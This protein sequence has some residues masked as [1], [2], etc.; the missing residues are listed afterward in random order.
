VSVL[1]QFLAL[2]CNHSTMDNRLL[3]LALSTVWLCVLPVLTLATFEA[4]ARNF[5]IAENAIQIH[6]SASLAGREQV[7]V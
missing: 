2:L 5:F 1:L 3:V 4:K 7:C 6:F